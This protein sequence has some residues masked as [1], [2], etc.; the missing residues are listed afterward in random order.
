MDEVPAKCH[1][2][3]EHRRFVVRREINHRHLV[4]IDEHIV[5][6]A[7][8]VDELSGQALDDRQSLKQD[9]QGIGN[10]RSQR[11]PGGA[12]TAGAGLL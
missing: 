9:G 11:S 6:A 2:E 12:R 4:A 10:G 5:W 8:A 3:R 1:T 7:V